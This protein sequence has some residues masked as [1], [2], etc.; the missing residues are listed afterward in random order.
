MA[1]QTFPTTDNKTVK[2]WSTGV[3]AEVLKKIF[4]LEFA[5][6]GS[7]Y[8]LQWK[9]EL[10]NSPGDTVTYGLRMQLT[11]APRTSGQ[12]LEGNERTIQYY[13]T[14][15]SIDEMVDAIR[16]D[17]RMG[18]QRVPFDIR[19][20][21]KDALTDQLSNGLDTSFFNQLA[22]WDLTGGVDSTFRGNNTLTMPDSDHRIFGGTSNTTDQGLSSG[23]DFTLDLIDI[24]L[25]KAKTLS[26]AI[27]PAKLD[28]LGGQFAYVCLIHPYQ[29]TQL[30][31]S[32]SRFDTINKAAMQ[33]GAIENNPLF[34]GNTLLWNGCLILESTRVTTGIHSSTKA[35][36]T[37][38]RRALFCGAQAGV[39]AWGATGNADGKFTWVEVE[40]EYNRE[41]G[42]SAGCLV[43]LQ[44][45]IF[46]SKDFAVITIS[47]HSAAS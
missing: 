17:N 33:G 24:A 14:N 31:A 43:G 26:P 21:A 1:V 23:D 10:G 7:D 20:D 46:N 25:E 28:F 35:E 5:G 30:R 3:E 9:D 13:D 6:K 36:L 2:K 29:M 32:S 11:D 34:T 39:V 27:R 45:N 16:F 18:R 8:L 4:W 19:S 38:V 47:S 22:G 42:V 44:K 12:S 41:W 37:D 40:F 15:V